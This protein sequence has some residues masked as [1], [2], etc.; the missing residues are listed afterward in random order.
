MAYFSIWGSCARNTA[1]TGH[2]ARLLLN[3]TYGTYKSYGSHRSYSNTAQLAACRSLRRRRAED[4]GERETFLI[5][6]L[7]LFVAVA[8]LTDGIAAQEQNLRDA[9][10]GVNLRGKRGC[11]ADFDGDLAAPLRLQ[12]SYVHDD[13]AIADENACLQSE[14]ARFG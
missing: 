12:G 14:I 3:G 10:V 5:L 7:A 13:T 4:E 8:C 11:V 1:Q 6:I 9:L 2:L